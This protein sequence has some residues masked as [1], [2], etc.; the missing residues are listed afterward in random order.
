MPS[1]SVDGKNLF[2]IE[3]YGSGSIWSLPVAGGEERQVLSNVASDGT[4]Y[5]VGKS[6]IYFIG[7]RPG[8][9]VQQLAL[10]SFASG[11]IRALADIARPVGLGI[12]VS[13]DEQ[14]ALYPQSDQM[15]SDLMLVE[16]FH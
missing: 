9:A 15:G 16:N 2:Y 7:K 14:L 1:E 8:A 12:A 4:M 10:L 6:G 11:E 13:P 3:S 5:A